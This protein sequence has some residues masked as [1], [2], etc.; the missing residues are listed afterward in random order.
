MRVVSNAGPLI[1]L[2]KVGRLELLKSLYGEI[3]I[4][5]G[6]RKEVVASGGERP[7]A[8]EVHEA[9]WIHVIA[10]EDTEAIDVLR[11]RL[12]LGESEVIV[13][14]TQIEADLLLIDEWRGRRVAE[15]RGLPK[16]GTLG[17]L[18]VAKKRGLLTAVM[19]IVDTLRDLDFRMGDELY[20]TIR[21][22][23]GEQPNTP[24]KG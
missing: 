8:K 14:A 19:P 3:Y 21:T 9:S 24:Q 11:Q 23:A 4:P 10:V 2:A 5:H 16:V 20:R 13:L 22:M 6:V 17:T 18:V 15:A 1:A 12:D 7:G